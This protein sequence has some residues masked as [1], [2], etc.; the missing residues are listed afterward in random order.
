MPQASVD[1]GSQRQLFHPGPDG[2][3]DFACPSD[4]RPRGSWYSTAP[5]VAALCAAA[6]LAVGIAMS[7]I[8]VVSRES[9][10]VSAARAFRPG[11]GGAAQLELVKDRHGGVRKQVPGADTRPVLGTFTLTEEDG[12]LIYGFQS[13]VAVSISRQAE[14]DGQRVK[15]DVATLRELH[16]AGESVE[17]VREVKA[18]LKCGQKRAET[19]VIAFRESLSE[20]IKSVG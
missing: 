5:V 3:L 1:V 12:Q 14:L 15:D 2:D 10:R 6:A 16:S 20:S 11:E 7:A 4:E 13:P 19:A 18:A 17:T 8:L 9:V